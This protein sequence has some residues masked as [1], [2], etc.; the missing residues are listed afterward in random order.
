MDDDQS[1]TL[2]M[3][4][5]VKGMKECKIADLSEKAIKHLFR[6]F[7]EYYVAG[8]KRAMCFFFKLC[9]ESFLQ[10]QMNTSYSVINQ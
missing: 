4:E 9:W 1:G 3:Q 7:G 2:D 10:V 5:F 6:Y 8:L